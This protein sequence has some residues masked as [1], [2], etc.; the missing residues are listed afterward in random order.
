MQFILR[1]REEKSMLLLKMCEEWEEP[2][3]R[4]MMGSRKFRRWDGQVTHTT[5]RHIVS[6]TV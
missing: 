1:E 4:V 6:Q 3:N 5:T 2:Q